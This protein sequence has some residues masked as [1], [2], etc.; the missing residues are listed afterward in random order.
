MTDYRD[1]THDRRK[2][3][4]NAAHEVDATHKAFGDP[5]TTL[6]AFDAHAPRLMAA[7]FSHGD[8]AAAR[9]QVARWPGQ[10]LERL[11]ADV[12]KARWALA[13]PRATSAPSVGDGVARPFTVRADDPRVPNLAPNDVVGINGHAISG[14][15][16]PRE[17]DFTKVRLGDLPASVRKEAARP[18]SRLHGAVAAAL[19]TGQPQ[20]IEMRGVGAGGG[21]YGKTGLG[22]I[23]GIGRFKVDTRGVVRP[24]RDGAWTLDTDVVGRPNTQDYVHDPRRGVIAGLVNDALRPIQDKMHGNRYTIDFFGSH[25]MAV[26]G[27]QK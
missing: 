11:T 19:A 1:P 12:E 9:A 24:G 5:D 3:I 8:L 20:P 10:I 25:H 23:G 18:N 14:D 17:V 7:G 2:A 26:S 15:G 16:S 4:W 22:Q 21:E 6:A 13:P 27:A